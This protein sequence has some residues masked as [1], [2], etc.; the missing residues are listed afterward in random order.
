MPFRP[1]MYLILS[2]HQVH[3]VCFISHEHSNYLACRSK[4]SYQLFYYD[5]PL[6]WQQCRNGLNTYTLIYILGHKDKRTWTS[7]NSKNSLTYLK[8]R[9]N[10]AH[11][12]IIDYHWTMT[13]LPRRRKNNTK[14]FIEWLC[15]L[16]HTV[17][18]IIFQVSILLMS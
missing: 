1:G 10:W 6:N 13:T 7:Y 5:P 18:C 4:D 15:C 2:G 3:P 16:T 9:V 17:G 14:Y 11:T 12:H 8:K